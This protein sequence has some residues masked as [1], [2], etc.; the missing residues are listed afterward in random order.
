MAHN[1]VLE[2]TSLRRV[3]MPMLERTAA[4]LEPCNFQRVLPPTK[5]AFKSSRRLHTAF[6]QHGAA[7]IELSG[8]WQTLVREPL[9]SLNLLPTA[10][11]SQP[12]RPEPLSS[13]AFL[14]DFL[15]PQGATSLLRKLAPSVLDKYERPKLYLGGAV[16]RLFTSSASSSRQP[17]ITT[18]EKTATSLAEDVDVQ[19]ESSI[20][21]PEDFAEEDGEVLDVEFDDEEIDNKYG[22]TAPTLAQTSSDAQEQSAPHVP[23]EEDQALLRERELEKMRNLLQTD[24]AAHFDNIW[25]IYHS[26]VLLLSDR[27]AHRTQFLD[28]VTKHQSMSHSLAL[29]I[30][31]NQWLT[32]W[33]IWERYPAAHQEGGKPLK[34]IEFERVLE[35]DELMHG[36]VTIVTRIQ[37]SKN[38][39]DEV[40]P[41]DPGLSDTLL[42]RFVYPCIHLYH[43]KT[44]PKHYLRLLKLLKDPLLYEKF[45]SLT[46]SKRMQVQS[47]ELYTAYRRLPGVKIRGY[48][49]H[50]M[51][52][53]CYYP[54]DPAGMEL[55]M[56][57][58]YARFGR[59]DIQGYRKYLDFYAR[60]GDIKSVE[61]LWGEYTTHYAEQRKRQ[62]H[63]KKALSDNADF[64]PLLHVYA[65]RGELGEVRRV[66][67]T[68]QQEYGPRLTTI[69][70]NIL[71]N[72]HAKAGE[73]DAAVRV[74]GV[75]RQAVTPDLY[76]Y[77]TMMGM[78]GSRGDLEFTLEL[79]RMAK[80]QGLQP[81]VTMID[82]VVEAYCQNGKFTDAENI[83]TMTTKNSSFKPGEL[84]PLWN[85]LLDHH[86]IRRDLLTVNRLLTVMTEQGVP[87]D[88][89]TYS[90]L[91]KGLALCRQPH[92]ALYLVQ[93]AVKSHS[94]KPTLQHYALLM[95]AFLRTGQYEQLFRTS[96]ILRDL[97]MP[98]TGSIL[99]R[100]LQA[101]GAWAQN[102]PGGRD[103][104][105]RMY[106]LSA[107]RQ[108]R[109]SIE[110]SREPQK[111]IPK[112]RGRKDPWLKQT[113]TA[114]TVTLR[115]EQARVLI[116]T[117]TQMRDVTSIQDILRLWKSSS[118]ETSNMQE[119]P[120]KLL[121]SL[122]LSAF[123][124]GQYD[125]VHEIWQLIFQRTL[126][127]SRVSSPGT[128]REEPVPSMRYVLN[129]P[130]RTVQRT[131]A[132]NNDVDR[133][134]TT[135][136]SVL[137]AGFKLDSK[138]WNYYVQLLATMNK[139][140]EAFMVCEER[141]MPF[142]RGW[143]RVRQKMATVQTVLPLEVRRRGMDP[144]YPRP[145]SYTLMVLSKAYMDLEQ[146][147][148]WSSEAD[149]LLSYI[150]QKAPST[151]GAVKT[152]LRTRAPLEMKL[153]MGE[154]KTRAAGER[155]SQSEGATRGQEDTGAP[156]AIREMMNIMT[157]AAEAEVERQRPNDFG[158]RE[159]DAAAAATATVTDATYVAGEGVFDGDED[160]NEDWLDVSDHEHD[161][162][163]WTPMAPD[164]VSSDWEEQ[165]DD[166]PPM[167]DNASPSSSSTNAEPKITPSSR[168][169][170]STVKS[171]GNEKATSKGN[172][173]QEA[174][175]D[176]DGDGRTAQDLHEEG[177]T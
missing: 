103:T 43:R 72:A 50:K 94:F 98:Q 65:T 97:G 29:A 113:P 124:E 76:S 36:L 88:S 125:E 32:I 159:P 101:L 91:L 55:V 117:F 158:G 149:R 15:Y 51:I 173:K 20:R 140:R 19:D 44:K 4:S 14:L 6:W 118:P 35:V 112:R 67:S 39:P 162:D 10:A 1:L 18:H 24:D 134:R 116:F 128:R 42:S 16:P 9:E 119:P 87:Y 147:S 11:H 28:Y 114:D 33:D 166:E 22:K 156:D 115:T 21:E 52:N 5:T 59:L 25:Q 49:M 64:Q 41:A 170:K 56:K 68:A 167:F 102:P 165:A 152:Q 143:Y 100:V 129:E 93:Q 123:Y 83:V 121:Q 7:D 175:S 138:N 70:W 27:N 26:Q 139:W 82:C 80:G 8:A 145:I 120:T 142:W 66:F 17:R 130:L 57:D 63:H 131:Y 86:A 23:Y 69:C 163:T 169:R 61:R 141:L 84:V 133:L 151:V 85:T 62:P 38:A 154:T 37:Q 74:F 136:A 58:F 30:K 45:L 31:S 90:K 54:D 176:A 107:L 2:A 95:S 126:H 132:A 77:G 89:E 75:L 160:G 53:N 148:A 106:L 144:H 110:S 34:W 13:S 164:Q 137:H 127:A 99:L 161:D 168:G 48:I 81:S 155:E 105:P 150:Q 71:L 40:R 109:K 122:M 78:S 79:Y 92:H 157:G 96:T 172:G 146:M 104:E 111:S 73:Y 153:F 108:F 12:T 174:A 60:R 46:T 177:K 3:L 135:V 171:N 47:H